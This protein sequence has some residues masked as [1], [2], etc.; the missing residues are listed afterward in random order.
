MKNRLC[1]FGGICVV[2]GLMLA[3]IGCQTQPAQLAVT[4]TPRL[5]QLNDAVQKDPT[6]AKN[7]AELGFA[8][9]MVGENQRARECF[10]R[11]RQLSL[12]D[13][14]TLLVIGWAYVNMNAPKEALA[15]FQ[16]ADKF[17]KTPV[18]QKWDYHHVLAIGYWING[19]KMAALKE[20]DLAAAKY[21]DDFAAWDKVIKHCESYTWTEK[22]IVYQIFDAWDRGYR[23]EK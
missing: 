1:S 16:E 12:E 7:I 17:D 19:D 21:P 10:A 5:K 4:P 13:S 9:A 2:A 15:A 8:W 11:A 14:S 23:L 20:Y 22:R 3:L 6:N 18:D